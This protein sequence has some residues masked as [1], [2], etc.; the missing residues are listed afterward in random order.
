MNDNKKTFF[1]FGFIVLFCM[2][3]FNFGCTLTIF[4]L[5]NPFGFS[6]HQD[7]YIG[8]LFGLTFLSCAYLG[9]IKKDICTKFDECEE[10]RND[11]KD[12]CHSDYK[13]CIHYK[14]LNNE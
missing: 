9:F 10:F 11:G 6:Y 13:S 7:Y 12:L 8:L 14:V 5:D 1:Q 4:L 3:I 2:I